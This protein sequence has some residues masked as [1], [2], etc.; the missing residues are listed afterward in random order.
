MF[1]EG[2]EKELFESQGFLK[3]ENLFPVSLIEK[4]ASEL[5]CQLDL[6]KAVMLHDKRYLVPV[7]IKGVFNK[8]ELYANE[9]LLALMRKFLGPGFIISNM[10]V[11]IS[12]PGAGDQH[13]HRDHDFLFLEEQE[14]SSRLPP[15]AITVAIPLVDIDLINGPTKIWTGSHRVADVTKIGSCPLYLLYGP[16]GCC[17]FWD[18]RAFHAGGANHS[19]LL[20]PLL[21][22]AYAR[23]W[24][25][26]HLYHLDQ[27]IFEESEIPEEYRFLFRRR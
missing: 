21:Y 5:L 10:G 2:N 1:A 24:F 19:K 15:F 6:E 22:I 11:V 17:Y 27:M 26:D 3:V 25:K 18:Y 13:I 8:P 7:P 16:K 20:R 4:F 14:L 9:K 23:P 12:L